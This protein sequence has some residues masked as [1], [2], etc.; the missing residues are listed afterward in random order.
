MDCD[1]LAVPVRFSQGSARP[2]ATLPPDAC[3]CHVHV[4]DGR[5]PATPGARLL[6]PDASA[7]DYR[8]LQRRLGTSRCVLVTPSTYGSDNRCMLDGLAALGPQ[9]RGVAVIDGSES[10]DQLQRLH[11]LGIRHQPQA[12]LVDLGPRLGQRQ[13]ARGALQQPQP[14]MRLQP[15]HAA[16]HGRG[17]QPQLPGRARKALVL[18]HAGEDQ[19]FI[20]GHGGIGQGAT[21]V[22]VAWQ[23]ILI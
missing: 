2:R 4:Y 15:P 23:A 9:A 8:A 10:D 11:G 16:A 1:S 19:H 22:F 5:Y 17:R 7:G 20:Q 21:P 18:H 6:P 13:R 14:E 3:D 12:G